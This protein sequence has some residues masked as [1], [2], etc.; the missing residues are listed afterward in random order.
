MWEVITY[1]SGTVIVKSEL[2]DCPHLYIHGRNDN[3]RRDIAIDLSVFLNYGR[4]LP[5]WA[6]SLKYD[7]DIKT[8]LIGSDSI[9]IN[10]IGPMILPEDDNGALN[11]QNDNSDKAKSD[12]VELIKR[13]VDAVRSTYMRNNFS[14]LL[15]MTRFTE[16]P[17]DVQH[18]ILR[19]FVGKSKHIGLTDAPQF[20]YCGEVLNVESFKFDTFDAMIE[21]INNR[22]EVAFILYPNELHKYHGNYVKIRGKFVNK[23]DAGDEN[24]IVENETETCPIK[25]IDVDGVGVID[26]DIGLKSEIFMEMCTDVFE[27]SSKDKSIK[28]V[29]GDRD[30]IQCVFD[31]GVFMVTP[32]PRAPAGPQGVQ[33]PDLTCSAEIPEFNSVYWEHD[34]IGGIIVLCSGVNPVL[35]ITDM[36]VYRNQYDEYTICDD[37]VYLNRIHLE[38]RRWLKR[39]TILNGRGL[40]VIAADRIKHILVRRFGYILDSTDVSPMSAKQCDMIKT[41]TESCRKQLD[42]SGV[43]DSDIDD[44]LSNGIK[45]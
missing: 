22:P 28:R 18:N 24:I 25:I 37:S 13:I 34:M 6:Q 39:D 15:T 20:E 45:D 26:T 23:I 41:I 1:T 44:I 5:E 35:K 38:L 4:T 29:K 11:W 16:L 2:P 9:S 10:A 3:Q 19:S 36:Y 30:T 17:R 42:D 43:P 12:R 27:V 32:T 33:G 21:Y 14:T 31:N 40:V 7:G 8:H